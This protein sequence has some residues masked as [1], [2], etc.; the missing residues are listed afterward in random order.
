MKSIRYAERNERTRAGETSRL[1]DRPCTPGRAADRA[2][3]VVVRSTQRQQPMCEIGPHDLCPLR[4]IGVNSAGSDALRCNR[5]AHTWNYPSHVSARVLRTRIPDDGDD[6]LL[7]THGSQ[8]IVLP[9]P[10]EP[11]SK[12]THFLPRFRQGIAVEYSEPQSK[13]CFFDK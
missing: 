10:L 4:N 7:S 12:R 2:E 11:V 9:F 1:C 6:A 5:K 3:P 13:F 8:L